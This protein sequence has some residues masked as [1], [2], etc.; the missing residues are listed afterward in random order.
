MA[1]T[2][3][4][5]FID[6]NYL[7]SYKEDSDLSDFPMY[8]RFRLVATN[9]ETGKE[10]YTK[11][12]IFLW[13]YEKI[14][15]LRVEITNMRDIKRLEEELSITRD[16]SL[17]FFFDG[18]ISPE[19][20]GKFI[21][22]DLSSNISVDNRV[23]LHVEKVDIG[24]N[25]QV[26]ILLNTEAPTV[27]HAYIKDISIV[28]NNNTKILIEKGIY[29][30]QNRPCHELKVKNSA[31]SSF[32]LSSYFGRIELDH[33]VGSSY[34]GI[35]NTLAELNFAYNEGESERGG[36]ISIKNLN[37]LVDFKYNEGNYAPTFFSPITIIE[38]C[39]LKVR[40]PNTSKRFYNRIEH[41]KEILIKNV[42]VE[43]A[44]AL[45]ASSKNGLEIRASKEDIERKLYD[46]AIVIEG[47]SVLGSD[48]DHIS[49]NQF[50]FIKSTIADVKG[51]LRL[52]QFHFDRTDILDDE[53]ELAFINA[54]AVESRIAFPRIVGARGAQGI[55]A[56]RDI[57]LDKASLESPYFD[58]QVRNIKNIGELSKKEGINRGKDIV[59]KA[60]E[61]KR[62]QLRNTLFAIVKED[63]HIDIDFD[64]EE[65]SPMYSGHLES[66][67]FY[68]KNRVTF[69]D[70][71][72]I[73]STLFI[74]T[75]TNIKNFKEIKGQKF[76]GLV[77]LNGKN[78]TL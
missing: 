59:I 47:T 69:R 5:Y 1:I 56:I 63:D 27:D 37:T 52:Y 16:E 24:A 74:D 10:I 65:K 46:K 9:K 17:N 21:N 7:F 75:D 22:I 51:D 45:L 26:D 73:K 57:E 12:N 14:K 18:Y 64:I 38:N 77:A 76:S 48:C 72:F 42:Q 2:I 30:K 50:G 66:C 3:N 71:G 34:G 20:N 23:Q 41:N 4:E 6:K 39:N 35:G 19:K 8:N 53:G 29:E 60:R 44:G 13:K 54:K 11:V 31:N 68:G 61:G 36:I 55:V 25:D 67:Y 62:L 15:N 58:L 40:V 32:I 49:L 33:S 70:V 43:I 28:G 78:Q